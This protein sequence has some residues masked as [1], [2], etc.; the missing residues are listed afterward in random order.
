MIIETKINRFDG[1]MVNDPRDPKENTCRVVTNFDILTN[2]RKITPYY[3][4]ES[5]DSGATTSQKQNFCIAL[6]TGT[7][8]RL[9][10]LGVVSGTGRGEVLMKDLTTSSNDLIDGGWL[11]PNNNQSSAGAVSFNLFVYYAKTGLIYGVRA[12]QYIW[13]FDPSSVASWS[14]SARDLTSFTNIAQG[15]VHSKDDILYIP[16]DNKILKNNN[17]S[18]TDAAL[19]L[20]SHLYITSICEYG[21]YLAI[22]ASPLSSVGDSYVYLWDRDATLATLSESIN[23]G[24][25]KLNILEEIDGYLI[26]ISSI[27]G[28]SS[29]L[30]DRVVFKYYFG[31]T[32]RKFKEIRGMSV[33]GK[34]IDKQKTNNRLYFLL[35]GTIGG[36]TKEGLFSVGLSEENFV[37][38]H[39]RTP[40]NNTASGGLKGFFIVNDFTFISY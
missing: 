11:T 39:E 3:D 20:P 15:L 7:T 23:W 18:W 2:P 34:G 28:L 32:V 35:T 17:G 13:A 4:S 1:G 12:S 25:G 38:I 8:Y 5:G 22:A 27:D 10:A 16:Y 37:L 14:D 33:S 40:N 30:T 26:G 36:A 19:T 9:Y 24:Q 31:N 6:R 29:V 21:N